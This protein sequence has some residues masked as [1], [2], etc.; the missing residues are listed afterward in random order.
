M[1]PPLL[2]IPLD[3]FRGPTDT[4]VACSKTRGTICTEDV[5]VVAE[6]GVDVTGPAPHVKSLWVAMP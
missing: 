6:V 2:G 1:Y 3:P 4:L 5:P